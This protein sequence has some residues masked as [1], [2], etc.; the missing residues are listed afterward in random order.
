MSAS[1]P[2]FS[3]LC[4]PAVVPHCV[5]LG[6]SSFLSGSEFP[7][8][9][10]ARLGQGYLNTLPAQG[11]RVGGATCQECVPGSCQPA[12]LTWATP[13]AETLP[14]VN[15]QGTREQV[16]QQSLHQQCPSSS[17]L[18]GR[19]VHPWRGECGMKTDQSCIRGPSFSGCCT[20]GH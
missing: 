8:L 16:C 20:K 9:Y 14:W 13:W 19:S 18:N 15:S 5:S 4:S 11:G 1:G 3:F 10:G 12:G 7:P 17:L 2:V 6:E